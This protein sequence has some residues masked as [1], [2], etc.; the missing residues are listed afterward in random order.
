MAKLNGKTN[1]SHNGNWKDVEELKKRLTTLS[2]KELDFELKK[3]SP[4]E[5]HNLVALTAST[6][7]IKKERRA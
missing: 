6:N 7:S 2:E 5:L 4:I 3:L 1:G